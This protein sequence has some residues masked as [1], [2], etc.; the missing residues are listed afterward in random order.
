MA[1]IVGRPDYKE[2][3]RWYN[4]YGKGIYP[5]PIDEVGDQ[6]QQQL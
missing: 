2:N 6:W 3:G 1:P 4:G 5:F